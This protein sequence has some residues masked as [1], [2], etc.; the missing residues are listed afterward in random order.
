G[1]AALFW[2]D[3]MPA[4]CGADCVP[5]FAVQVG[6]LL[7]A[8]GAPKVLNSTPEEAVVSFDMM[9]LLTRLTANASCSDTPAPSQPATLLTMMLLVTLTEFQNAGCCGKATT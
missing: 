9:V 4:G 6:P 7:L 8:M 3:T 5:Q 1:K 2:M